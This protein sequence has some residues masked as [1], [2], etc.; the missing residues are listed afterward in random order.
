MRVNSQS[1]WAIPL[2]LETTPPPAQPRSRFTDQNASRARPLDLAQLVMFCQVAVVVISCW[3]DRP[4]IPEMPWCAYAS[5]VDQPKV[6]FS[7]LFRPW[8]APTVSL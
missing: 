3:S 2:Q 7:L 8:D 5:A 6:D 1:G 4:F